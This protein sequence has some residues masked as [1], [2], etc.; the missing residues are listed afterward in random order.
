MA[1]HTNVI[2]VLIWF[3]QLPVSYDSFRKRGWMTAPTPPPGWYPDPTGSGIRY[4]DGA[5]WTVPTTRE[6]APAKKLTVSRMGW[7]YI[8]VIAC[9]LVIFAVVEGFSGSSVS[10]GEAQ[11]MAIS[12]CQ[13]SIRDQLRDPDSAQF[14]EWKAWPSPKVNVPVG[15]EFHPESGDK[16]Y[17][18]TGLANAKNGFGGYVGDQRFT[19]D[20][21][22]KKNGDTVAGA[23]K[24]EPSPSGG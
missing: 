18:A 16:L 5:G 7:V 15:M 22:V 20:A 2:N 24:S 14:S 6:H 12:T 21:V 17:Y 8:G 9:L 23:R 11:R 4:W 1:N 19:C 13:G 3:C 10:S